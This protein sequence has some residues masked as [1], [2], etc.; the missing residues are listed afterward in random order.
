MGHDAPKLGK[1]P[2]ICTEMAVKTKE[3]E[4]AKA[5]WA[6]ST[7]GDPLWEEWV[8]EDEVIDLLEK[9]LS[10]PAPS[11]PLPRELWILVPEEPQ[12][13]S[14][15]LLLKIAASIGYDPAEL[16][17]VVMASMDLAQL[18]VWWSSQSWLTRRVLA[19][20]I[21]MPELPF[22]PHEYWAQAPDLNTLR[23]D[24]NARKSLWGQIKGWRDA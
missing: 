22:E 19:L 1:R 10:T 3:E 5:F 11:T 7:I 15:P 9:P 6:G 18:R 13:Q 20:G 2:L 21:S 4:G 24:E 16:Q 23:S 17:I 14:R 12:A 8:L